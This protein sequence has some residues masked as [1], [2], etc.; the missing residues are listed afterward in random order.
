VEVR[1]RVRTLAIVAT[2]ALAML[3]AGTAIG[4]TLQKGGGPVTAVK[5]VTDD[6]GTY[7]NA[8]SWS[9]IPGMSLAVNIP[10][11]EKAL[12]IVTFST[13]DS[14]YAYGA[15]TAGQCTAR[16]VVDG[17]PAQ[18]LQATFASATSANQHLYQSNSMQ[19]VAGPKLAGAHTVKVQYMSNDPNVYFYVEARTLTVLRSKV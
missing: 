19:F 13:V 4:S 10:T 2:V 12:L 17:N 9:D 11:G 18:P 1:V 16:V 15:G 7:T 5:T 6:I 14:C 3:V 8:A